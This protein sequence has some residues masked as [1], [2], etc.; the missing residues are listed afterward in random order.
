MKQ[1]LRKH[2][3]S[4]VQWALDMNKERIQSVTTYALKLATDPQ[5]KERREDARCICCFYRGSTI[6][7]SA[8]TQSQCGIC[9]K[10]LLSGSTKTDKLCKECAINHKLCRDC[11]STIDLKEPRWMKSE[12]IQP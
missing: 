8:M 4:D 10:E 1:P 7:G 6:A 2:K 9:E 11:G 3:K 5:K 12:D